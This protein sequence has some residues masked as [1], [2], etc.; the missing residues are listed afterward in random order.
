MS[1]SYVHK[2]KNDVEL[3]HWSWRTWRRV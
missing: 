2:A 3:R 1:S